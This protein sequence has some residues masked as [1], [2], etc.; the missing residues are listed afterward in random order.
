MELS[1]LTRKNELGMPLV[2]F[3]TYQLS[4]AQAETSVKEALK[5]GFRHIDAAEGYNNEEGTG[6]GIKE[7]GVPRSEIFVTSKLFPGYKPWGAPEKTYEQTIETLK[8]Q[9]KQLQLD[10]VDLY[11]IHAPLAELRLEQWRALMELKRLGLTR[12]IGVSNYNEEKIKE[13]LNAGLAKPEA[14]QVEFHPMNTQIELTKYMKE[15]SIVPIAYSSLAPLSNWRSVE[16]QG[17]EVLA[18][19]KKEGQFFIKDI[20][21][22]LNVSEAKLLLRWGLQHGYSVLTRS[23]KPERI[24]EN[25]NLFDF[26]IPNSDMELLNK[27]NKNQPFAWAANGLNP[28]EAAPLLK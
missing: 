12:H 18:D 15:N 14:N 16:G 1:K 20:A 2:G 28:M 26:E 6:R 4:A 7:S 23:T 17:G 27:L 24:K 5:A 22:K 3:G 25:L 19:L 13:I 9:L 8:N 21:A 10:Y 11:L